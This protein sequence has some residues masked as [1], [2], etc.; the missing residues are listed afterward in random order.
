MYYTKS[1]LLFFVSFL[2]ISCASVSC[3]EVN[4]RPNTLDFSHTHELPRKSFLKINK[5]INF[6]ICMDETKPEDCM[7]QRM[8]STG[9]GFIIGNAPGGAFIMTAAHVCDVADLVEQFTADPK[10]TF[11]GENTMVEDV[12]GQTF[13]AVVLEMDKAADL[14]V[15]F[16]HGLQ[17][18]PVDIAYNGPRPGDQAHN[19]AAPVGFMA[20]GLIPTLHGNYNGR[21]GRYAS[22]SIPAVGGSSGSPIFDANGKV[23]GMIHSVHTRFQFLTFSPTHKEIYS[24][25]AKYTRL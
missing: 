15:A 20:K 25:A 18:P 10:I 2:F 8:R 7:K 21:Y 11:L 16:V 24:L 9:S 6:K 5:N 23:I 12:R 17:S 22:Y 3:G 1:L 14:C 4:T 13:S 19:L